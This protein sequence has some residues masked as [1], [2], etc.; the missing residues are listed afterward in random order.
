LAVLAAA[1]AAVSL[2]HSL[3]QGS[4]N[5]QNRQA[6]EGIIEYA[7]QVQIVFG[8]FLGASDAAYHHEGGGGIAQHGQSVISMTALL[9][10]W[11][12]GYPACINLLPLSLDSPDIT[13]EEKTR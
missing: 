9:V 8:K 4:F 6:A 2:S 10:G 13:P 7:R 12:V 1:I 3:E 11:P 5:R